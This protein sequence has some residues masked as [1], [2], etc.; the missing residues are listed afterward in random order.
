M[1]TFDPTSPKYRY[2]VADLLS[3][4]VIAE[5]PF[6]GVSYERA[7]K[8]A[9]SFSGSIAI[10]DRTAALNLYDTTLP[11]RTSLYV[12]R[13]NV[14]V[15]GGIIWSRSYTASSK[16][17]NVSA[18][19]FQSY[20]YHR[21]IWKT[22][23]H[24]FSATLVSTGF[25]TSLVTLD[26][27]SFSFVA[28][29]PVKIEFYEISN[30]QYDGYYTILSPSLTTTT[31]TVGTP[32]G[33]PTIPA[34][35]YTNITVRVR[36]DTYDYVRQLL[37]EVALDFSG[38][39]FPN[40]EIQPGVSTSYTVTQKQLSSNVA[41]LT[42]SAP[43]DVIIGQ[44]ID[45]E[46]VDSTFDGAHTVID[47]T[48]TT[49]SYDLTASDVSP[50][51]VTGI[52]RSVVSKKL[53]DNAIITLTTSVAHGFQPGDIITVQNVDDPTATDFCFCGV[54]SITEVPT[55]TTLKYVVYSYELNV[56]ETPVSGTVVLEPRLWSN[57]YGPY[58]ANADIGIEYSTGDYSLVN[59]PNV[60]YRGFELRS[61]GEELD[62]YSDIV[63]GFEYRIDCEYDADTQSFS[64]TFVLLPINFPNPPGT[65]QVAPLSRYGADRFV[66]EY[67]GNINEVTIDESAENSAT[68]FF[69][70]GNIGDLGDEASQPY[71]VASATD[72][73]AAGWPIL[74]MEET[75][76]DEFDEELLYSHAQRYL[77]EFRPPVSDVKVSIN[78]SLSPIVGSYKPGDWCALIINDEFVR[79]RLA[80]DLEVRDD[81]IVR[82]IENIK[83]SVP[84]G[85]AFPEQV[86]LE[87]IP[88][89]EVDKRG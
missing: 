67:P 40:G 48:S 77:T 18:S 25:G 6:Q 66:F 68:R 28:G 52:T 31:F 7:I 10:L 80:S 27:G 24:D 32:S 42:V 9:G 62:E 43:H 51:A 38:I 44:S 47:A 84:D 30:F 41:T 72:L 74:D 73:L 45:V 70:V 37:D 78:G 39:Q 1:S 79:M 2:F 35:T 83:V 76:Q 56:E 13:D 17:L 26:F 36:V 57:T 19:E 4:A 59:T 15:W 63:D 87:L 60:T 89:W 71:S 75:R 85:T 50:T 54:H 82:K 86:E 16:T 33:K 5:I 49:V 11:G 29:S 81:I 22:Y 20:F 58:P 88:E 64:R 3:N 65:G 21:N 53:E 46:N 69:V 8:A 55:P 12:V 61:V 34:G 14:C 23:S